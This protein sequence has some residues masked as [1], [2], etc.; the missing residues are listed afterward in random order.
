MAADD[1]EKSKNETKDGSKKESTST[2]GAKQKGK[3]KEN[4]MPPSTVTVAISKQSSSTKSDSKQAQAKSLLDK[5]LEPMRPN[6]TPKPSTS[7]PKF[8]KSTTASATIS[9]PPDANVQNVNYP[10]KAA[11]QMDVIPSYLQ[12]NFL[13]NNQAYTMPSQQFTPQPGMNQPQL[14]P[15][16]QFVTP[17][18]AQMV[19]Q[20]YQPN[21]MYPQQ[22]LQPQPMYP[23]P[24]QYVQPMY[25]SPP[26]QV[27]APVQNQQVTP[28][29]ATKHRYHEDVPPF[30]LPE[31]DENLEDG[32]WVDVDEDYE[33]E[34][35]TPFDT[36]EWMAQF[37]EDIMGGEPAGDEIVE[38]EDGEDDDES[39]N[40]S[41][42]TLAR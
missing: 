37:R 24:I 8:T 6:L 27:A 29:A 18:G 42:R 3:G 26:Q 31:Q 30:E 32:E 25:V 33:Q 7:T 14:L 39:C 16:N 41:Y 20:T 22:M 12:Q 19:P 38:L 11:P 5:I 17:P 15:Q 28:R 2:K 10:Y 9:K 36:N 23:Q 13:P 1:T 40:S 34:H 35:V 4:T 21:Q